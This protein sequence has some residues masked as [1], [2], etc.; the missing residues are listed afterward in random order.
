M[1]EVK[2]KYFAASMIHV[3][4][5][6]HPDLKM[7]TVLMLWHLRVIEAHHDLRYYPGK[8]TKLSSQC[9]KKNH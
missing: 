1:L 3:H 7:Q 6:V 4:F 8:D 2:H 9:I 5:L